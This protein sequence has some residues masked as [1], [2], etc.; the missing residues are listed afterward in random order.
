MPAVFLLLDISYTRLISFQEFEKEMLL[1]H[2]LNT[3]LRP[4]YIFFI[5]GVVSTFAAVVYTCMG[6]VWVRFNGWV[7]RA[8]EPRTF[9][10]QVALLYLGGVWFLG[11]FL[12][13]IYGI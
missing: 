4:P 11:C 10:V 3:L 7:Y 12:Y 6:K 5:L 1:M 13:K 2:D 8:E 9:W